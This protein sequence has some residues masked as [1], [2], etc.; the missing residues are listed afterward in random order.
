MKYQILEAF[1]SF[2][3]SVDAVGNT[4]TKNQARHNLF[5]KNPKSSELNEARS[6]IFHS[7]VTK[8][9]YICKRERPDIELT[10]SYLTTRVSKSTENDWVK[11]K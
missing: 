3:L 8:L 2:E 6:E 7:A 9:L 1:E 11:L 4:Y 5:T 10:I